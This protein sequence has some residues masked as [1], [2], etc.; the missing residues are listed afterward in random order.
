MTKFIVYG[1]DGWPVETI[2]G[3]YIQNFLR[4]IIHGNILTTLRKGCSEPK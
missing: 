1:K 3:R 4:R 2:E